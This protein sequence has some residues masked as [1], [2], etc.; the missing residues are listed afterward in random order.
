MAGETKK[1]LDLSP[2]FSAKACDFQCGSVSVKA[3][4]VGL[5]TRGAGQQ[6]VK[7]LLNSWSG[8]AEIRLCFPLLDGENIFFMH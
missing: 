3:T 1:D 2:T 8:Q 4:R 7:R 5:K 6:K